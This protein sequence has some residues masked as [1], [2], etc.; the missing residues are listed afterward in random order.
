MTFDGSH[1]QTLIPNQASSASEGPYTASRL[2][3]FRV[4]L[5]AGRCPVGWADLLGTLSLDSKA[6]SPA[7]ALSTQ[8]PLAPEANGS[9]SQA[10]HNLCWVGQNQTLAGPGK[11]SAFQAH[12]SRVCEP[13]GKLLAPYFMFSHTH[14][15][16]PSLLLSNP[17][18]RLRFSMLKAWT[19][20]TPQRLMDRSAHL[21]LCSE[22]KKNDRNDFSLCFSLFGTAEKIIFF[23]I[24]GKALDKCLQ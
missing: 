7:E 24:Y 4:W 8:P 9:L 18:R 22:R 15:G 14:S 11:G 2:P 20:P 5:G 3:Y 17:D 10:Y 12:N 13:S 21:S 16:S 6:S 23:L 1:Y 19:L